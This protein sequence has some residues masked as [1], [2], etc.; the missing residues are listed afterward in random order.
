MRYLKKQEIFA[1]K[2]VYFKAPERCPT[3]LFTE[4]AENYILTSVWS[5]QRLA[6]RNT[7]HSGP[8]PL[9]L[10]ANYALDRLTMDPLFDVGSVAH[11]KTGPIGISYCTVIIFEL[12]FESSLYQT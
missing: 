10:I 11:L 9:L 5:A 1:K 8:R 6:G 2:H 7:Q 3:V 4:N 12:V